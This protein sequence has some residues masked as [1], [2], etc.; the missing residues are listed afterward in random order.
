MSLYD[1]LDMKEEAGSGK[2][3]K[4]SV[5]SGWSPGYKLL[6][7][8][9][10]AKKASV[11]QPKR[12]RT[13]H[14]A[15]VVDLKRHVDPD[16]PLQFNMQTGKLERATLTSIQPQA[17]IAIAPI[18]PSIPSVLI[19]SDP[20]P[21][22]TGV[23]DEYDPLRPNEYDDVVKRLKDEKEKEREKDRRKED[24]RDR[25]RRDVE[26]RDDRDR[27]RDRD[28]RRQERRN[29]DEE[30]SE[31]ETMRKRRA[32]EDEE[33]EI[34][35]SKRAGAAIAPPSVLLE[36][37]PVNPEAE[38]P[39][40]P[41]MGM[42]MMGSVASKIM[43]KYGYKEGQ[44]LGKSEQGMSTALYVEKTSKR[45][46]KIIHEKDIPKDVQPQSNTNLFKNLSKVILLQ[47]M[48]GPG[49]VDAE[50][51]PETA[52]EC[53]KYGKVN[54]CVIFEVPDV[55]EEEGVRIFVEFERQESAVKALVD[56]NGRFFG[57]RVVKA[58]FYNLDKF[59][60]MDYNG[61]VD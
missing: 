18:T 12:N 60:R 6:A 30:E 47:N 22:F 10:Q 11:L 1:D 17:S 4:S 16:A 57:G 29:E 20:I 49:E 58:C 14:L 21:S 51:E 38:R 27:D 26:R 42:A 55:P 36:E 48:V 33:D 7:S 25:E 32:Q 34:D 45:G 53:T 2:I 43:A 8:T 3:T 15:P 46:G 50:L 40:S 59:R 31:F 41:T 9:L 37:T 13:S 56:L 39:K 19:A 52:E 54:K 35:R 61:F 28:R 23:A 5:V 24:R 44:G